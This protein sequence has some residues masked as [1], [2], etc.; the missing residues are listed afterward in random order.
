MTDTAA[1]SQGRGAREEEA[2]SPGGA[3]QHGHSRT[4]I[5]SWSLEAGKNQNVKTRFAFPQ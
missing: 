1:M 2:T 3:Q 5:A 4:E